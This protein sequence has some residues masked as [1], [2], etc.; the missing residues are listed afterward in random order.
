[1]Q[2]I[3]VLI[4]ILLLSFNFNSN[5]SYAL[6]DSN[7]KPVKLE[8]SFKDLDDFIDKDV[9]K[10]TYYSEYKISLDNL[11]YILNDYTEFKNSSLEDVLKNLDSLD[12]DISIKTKK[13]ASS[14]YNFE[15]FFKLLS[16]NKTTP[17]D[18]MMTAI[19]NKY[20]SFEN[21]L[22]QFKKLALNTNDSEWIFLVSDCNGN[23]S[24]CTSKDVSCPVIFKKQIILCLNL[25]KKFYTDKEKY[26]NSFFNYVN[27]NQASK[28][29]CNLIKY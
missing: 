17:K 21:F 16:T 22:S 10:E 8:Y 1:M 24:M 29:Y 11:M 3:I 25:D 28:N 5:H 2:K 12:D 9:L 18:E 23:L 4:F 27:W 6:Q 19:V 13:Y 14:A 20:S 7:F 26:I 15:S